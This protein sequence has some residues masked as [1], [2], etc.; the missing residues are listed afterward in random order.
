MILSHDTTVFT[1]DP[2]V[3]VNFAIIQIGQYFQAFPVKQVFVVF[4]SYNSIVQYNI[5]S[6]QLFDCLGSLLPRLWY[7]G[8]A[9]LKV[10][11]AGSW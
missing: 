4:Q 9:D 7:L 5:F 3:E 6:G 10:G 11:R 2:R 1:T 8:I